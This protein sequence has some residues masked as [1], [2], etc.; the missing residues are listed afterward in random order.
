MSK[1]VDE[2]IAYRDLKITI[3][4]AIK[5]PLSLLEERKIEW[6]ARMDY[7]TIEVFIELFKAKSSAE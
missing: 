2:E 1:Y 7:E 5:R 6:L 4:A 3:E